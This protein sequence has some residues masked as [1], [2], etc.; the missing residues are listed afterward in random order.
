MIIVSRA[1]YGYGLLGG[2]KDGGLEVLFSEGR[3]E[4]GWGRLLSTVSAAFF[5]GLALF[6]GVVAGLLSNLYARCSS[7]WREGSGSGV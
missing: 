3:D 5:R 6:E 4:N 7:R 1:G 2:Q